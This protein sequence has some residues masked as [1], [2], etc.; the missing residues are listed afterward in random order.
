MVIQ[1]HL[2]KR[3]EDHAPFAMTGWSIWLALLQQKNYPCHIH[4][5][6]KTGAFQIEEFAWQWKNQR[7]IVIKNQYGRLLAHHTVTSKWRAIRSHPLIITSHHDNV[8]NAIQVSGDHCAKDINNLGLLTQS[9][10]TGCYGSVL[11]YGFKQD[12]IIIIIHDWFCDA[13]HEQLIYNVIIT[14]FRR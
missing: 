3:L 9:H 2:F 14:C 1:S 12:V 6:K 13:E 8:F 11:F 4:K 10:T 7:T 5:E